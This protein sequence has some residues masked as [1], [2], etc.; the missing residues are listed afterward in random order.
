MDRL[1]EKYK[2]NQ[3]G[4]SDSQTDTKDRRDIIIEIYEKYNVRLRSF[5]VRQLKNQSDVDDVAQEVY[6]RIIKYWKPNGRKASLSM[7]QTI[8]LN[9]INNRYNRQKSPGDHF[10]VSVDDIDIKSETPSPEDILIFKKRFTIM[11]SVFKGLKEDSRRAFS[12]HRFS[13]CSYEEIAE[14]MGISKSMVQKHISQT[15]FQLRKKM[16]S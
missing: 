14:K 12:L 15:L 4:P 6:F 5:L 1:E 3:K 8:A 11:Q 2:D 9:I 7:L 10:H 13:G 16:M